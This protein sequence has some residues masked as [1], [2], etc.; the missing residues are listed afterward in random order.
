MI[1]MVKEP[2]AGRVKTRLGREIG[3]TAAAWWYRHQV[4][5][6]L[7]RLRDPRWDI[8]LAVSPDHSV[9]GR[10]WPSDLWRMPQGGGDL[11]TR[12]ARAFGCSRGPSILIGSD[13]PGVSRGH[14]EHAF[15]L[16]REK[17]SV[18][19]PS[20]DGGFWLVG[21]RTPQSVPLTFFQGVRWSHRAT[22]SD[23]LRCFPEPP[24]IADRLSDVDR[25]SDLLRC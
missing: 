12:M 24:A 13:I 25:A 10:D 21:F 19:G 11:G 20:E 5:S 14:I 2:R 3:M 22:L 8:V 23:T 15:A 17:T 4:R 18:I 16:L 9:L 7:R 6:L 1:I